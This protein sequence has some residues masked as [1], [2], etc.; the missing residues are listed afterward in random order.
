MFLDLRR[1]LRILG[2]FAL[3]T[4]YTCLA[5]FQREVQDC[6]HLDQE[7]A[8]KVCWT[9]NESSDII[10]FALEVS[11]LGWVGF[12]FAQKIHRMQNYDVIVGKIQSGKESLTVS[13]YQLTP[14]NTGVFIIIRTHY[15]QYSSVITL[16]RYSA[17]FLL[18]KKCELMHEVVGYRQ[19]RFTPTFMIQTQ[20]KIL[21]IY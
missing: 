10:N 5:A 8:F 12:G 4:L 21:F 18:D 17:F 15:H 13:F 1:M 6:V 19:L 9:Y 11:T 20:S 2:Y 16:I 7:K 14:F 3:I